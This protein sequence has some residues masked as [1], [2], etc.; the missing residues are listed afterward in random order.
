MPHL[1]RIIN[2]LWDKISPYYHFLIQGA[3][4]FDAVEVHQRMLDG[5]KGRDPEEVARWLRID[6]SK[7]AEATIRSMDRLQE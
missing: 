5:M 7:A 6:I 4:G 3:E 2:G 1:Q